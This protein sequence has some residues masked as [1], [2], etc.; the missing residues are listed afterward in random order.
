MKNCL[1]NDRLDGVDTIIAEF[2]QQLSL[3]S[4]NGVN[5]EEV[6]ENRTTNLQPHTAAPK[7]HSYI[8]RPVCWP[9]N[10]V[11]T[12]AFD[13]SL[14]NENAF[15]RIAVPRDNGQS[16]VD[17]QTQKRIQEVIAFAQNKDVQLIEES[18]DVCNRINQALKR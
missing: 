5:V 1:A 16:I 18:L 17:V 2:E 4:L 11:E 10:R 13:Q 3:P 7:R 14:A 12:V 8:E 15:E 9:S 6:S